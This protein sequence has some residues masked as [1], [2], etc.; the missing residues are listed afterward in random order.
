[1]SR[2]TRKLLIGAFLALAAPL[3][4]CGGSETTGGAQGEASDGKT[5]AAIK[6]RGYIRCGASPHAAQAANT[7]SVSESV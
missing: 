7:T 2:R 1:M 5:L 4:G 3:A 6:A